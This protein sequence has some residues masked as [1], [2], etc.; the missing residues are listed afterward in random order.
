VLGQDENLVASAQDVLSASK[1]YNVAES[2]GAALE[3]ARHLNAENI[4]P[5]ILANPDA[6]D[7]L[8]NVIEQYGL[9][10][11]VAMYK[12]FAGARDLGS[13]MGN[14]DALDA[15]AE[16]YVASQQIGSGEEN[17]AHIAAGVADV[18]ELAEGV[19]ANIGDAGRNSGLMD[20][21]PHMGTTAHEVRD[22]HEDGLAGL[23]EYQQNMSGVQQEIHDLGAGAA[24]ANQAN[25]QAVEEQKSENTERHIQKTLENSAKQKEVFEEV[26][27]ETLN[28]PGRV[29][30]YLK[31]KLRD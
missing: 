8:H 14:E 31:D 22:G 9:D 11:Q 15:H 13:F 5:A 21:A 24:S 29:Y 10:E 20:S 3:G 25:H 23:P 2:A 27:T 30:E 28:A 16:L 26:D 4:V 19:P 7:A 6:R 17:S 1:A 12:E 18:L